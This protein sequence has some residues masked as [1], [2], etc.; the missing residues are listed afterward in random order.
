MTPRLLSPSLVS[1]AVIWASAPA[2]AVACEPCACELPWGIRPQIEGQELP[3]NARFLVD[4]NVASDNPKV[5]ELKLESI[6]WV[7][8][9]TEQAVAFKTVAA[10]DDPLVVWVVAD[11]LLEG[12]TE[13]LISVGDDEPAQFA[14]SFKTSG[15]VDES[16]PE[17]E[18]P[19]VERVSASGACGESNSARIVWRAIQDDGGAMPYEPIVRAR[20]DN[21]DREVELFLDAKNLVPGRGVVLANPLDEGGAECWRN[22][23]LPFKNETALSVQLTVY[24]R[25]GNA[26][27]LEPFDVTLSRDPGGECSSDESECGIAR[28]PT[29]HSQQG[30]AA[31]L[32]LAVTGVLLVR[33]R[34]HALSVTDPPTGSN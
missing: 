16:P 6:H 8:V 3:R 9:E 1:V 18:V 27:E 31:A 23:G 29:D 19:K 17:A 34:V 15:V 26:Q 25:A 2:P 24:D 20:V 22:F 28:G 12:D 21:G 33:R 5:A 32:L 7:A 14:S 13:Y 4:L 30:S 11:E 10:G